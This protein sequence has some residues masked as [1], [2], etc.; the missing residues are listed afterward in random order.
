MDERGRAHMT[1]IW[2][3]GAVAY[4]VETDLTLR[5]LDA[6]VDLT[7]LRRLE[8]SRLLGHD[9]PFGKLVDA[10]LDDPPRL[11]H[12][13]HA[14]QVSIVGIAVLS[15]R[16]VEFD[17]VVSLVRAGLTQIPIDATPAQHWTR[18]AVVERQLRRQHTYA[19]RTRLPDPVVG[20]QAF[21]LVDMGRK[22][23]YELQAAI[24][25]T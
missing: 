11:S 14:Y 18:D 6:E 15:Q 12:L 22:T 19:D 5:P 1:A 23:L 4:D 16:H 10:L 2:I 7:I 21:V 25:P 3:R 17:F 24:G 9:R 8:H 13:R 20:E